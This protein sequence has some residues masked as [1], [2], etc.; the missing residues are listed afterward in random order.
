VEL[1]SNKRNKRRVIYPKHFLIPLYLFT[2]RNFFLLGI[3]LAFAC[4][5]STEIPTPVTDPSN[6]R[7]GAELDAATLQTTMLILVNNLRAKGCTCGTTKKK[8]VAAVA[9]N[10]SLNAAA[11]LH[12]KDMDELKFFSHTGSDGGDFSK[13]AQISGYKGFASG[14]NIALGYP[15]P[16]GVI[17]GWIAS[18]GHCNN[19]MNANNKE[20]GV[21]KVGKYW[22][23]VF[24]EK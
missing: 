3:S 19:M 15:T 16:Q 10:E 12:A 14:E 13:R 23:Q 4:C 8:P 20:M 5:S 6:Q 17:E 7:P 18:E 1:R 9:F 11:N 22:V 24:G 21:A 2:M